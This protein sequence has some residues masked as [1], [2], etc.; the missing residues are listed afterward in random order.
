[1]TSTVDLPDLVPGYSFDA[2]NEPI[3]G[4]HRD[5]VELILD[6]P[7]VSDPLDDC[8]GGSDPE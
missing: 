8:E 2:L 7:D 4:R 1:M 3:Y 5:Y 6:R